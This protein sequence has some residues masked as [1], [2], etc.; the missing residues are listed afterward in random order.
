MHRA[1]SQVD[2]GR[3]ED[4]VA[5]Q[6]GQAGQAG[7]GRSDARRRRAWRDLASANAQVRVRQRGARVYVVHVCACAMAT[8]SKSHWC[9]FLSCSRRTYRDACAYRLHA[10]S[11]PPPDKRAQAI[12][13][14][15]ETLRKLHKLREAAYFMLY[16]HTHSDDAAHGTSGAAG[17]SDSSSQEQHRPPAPA[18]PA[19]PPPRT[20]AHDDD[21]EVL[22]S[23]SSDSSEEADDTIPN[24]VFCQFTKVRKNV[25]VPKN[26]ASAPNEKMWKAFLKEGVFETPGERDGGERS[27]LLQRG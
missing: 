19:P 2:H 20:E 23:A 18:P 5:G 4:P 22:S 12:Q 21:D 10:R 15:A 27:I 16:G 25:A 7:Q 26:N 11:P 13:E 17:P 8:E 3:A 24:R 6:V 14:F 9:F 1:S